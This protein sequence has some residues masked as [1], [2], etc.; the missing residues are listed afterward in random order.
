MLDNF[1]VMR[2]VGKPVHLAISTPDKSC[3]QI[4]SLLMN[5]SVVS[6]LL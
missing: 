2:F 3:D 4:P 6:L 5:C 1:L